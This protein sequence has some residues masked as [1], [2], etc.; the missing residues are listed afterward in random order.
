MKYVISYDVGTTGIKTCIFKIDD[1]I[2]LVAGESASYPLL[3]LPHGGSEQE[4]EDWWRKMCE[5]TKVVLHKS[6]LKP[7]QIEGI[8]FCAQMQSLVLV[9]KEGKPVRRAMGY[10]DQRATEEVEKGISHGLQIAGANIFKLIPSLIITGAVTSS[11]K[12]PVWKLKWV[13][14]H[15]PEVFAKAYK[16]LDV[17]DYLVLRCT[18]EF[19]MTPDSAFSTLIYDN[20]PKK[21]CWSKKMCDMFHIDMNLLPPIVSSTE[22]V[23]K[24]LTSKAALELGLVAG[25]KV[26]SGGG[27]SSLIGIGA[28]CTEVGET[29]MYC[30]TSGWVNTITDKRKV[31]TGAMI[32]SITGVQPGKYNYFAEMET[33]GKC[34]EWV[35]DHLALDEIDVYLEKKHVAESR[36]NFEAKFSSLFEYLNETIKDIP[37]GSNGIIF[38]P[39]LH[40]NRC[41][42]EDPNAAGMFFGIKI[43]TGKRDM[44]HAVL[45]GIFY[46]LRWMLECQ[47]NKVETSSSI[48]FVGGGAMNNTSCQLLADIIGRDIVVVKDPQNVGAVGAA[49]ISAVG[50]GEI[51]RI[52]D[53]KQYIPI[54]KTYRPRKEKHVEYEAYYQIFKR[55]YKSNK[56]NY[57]HL[58]K[59]DLVDTTEKKRKFMQVLKFVLFSISAGIIQLISTTIVESICGAA[60]PGATYIPTVAYLIGLVLSVLWNFTFN[61]KFTFKSSSN[62][63]KAMGLAF[64]FYVFFTPASLF[65]QGFLTTGDVL[66]FFTNNPF[67]HLGLPGIVG[68]LVC[69][70]FNMILEFIWQ[71]NIVFKDTLDKEKAK[72]EKK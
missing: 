43:N 68:T 1:K 30:G 20:R 6:G 42:F 69:M 50:L 16:W 34:F 56:K 28:G 32:A 40:G 67:F 10:M 17:K 45:E 26:F 3:T 49:A 5:T 48:R 72:K 4:P 61:R 27:D 7:N 53:V 44:I 58:E 55:L 46:H 24:G 2:E 41:P 29:H 33:A 70:V 9:D 39:W 31:D 14:A 57:E 15:E 36:P 37:P 22:P 60:T 25:T 66:G 11:P 19:T 35:K 21:Q 63:P 8:S 13:E 38:T 52:E 54:H 64:L 12:D 62:V 51:K 71:K 59:K 23:G 65:L 47:E 18:D